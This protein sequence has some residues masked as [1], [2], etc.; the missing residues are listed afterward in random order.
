MRSGVVT[1]LLLANVPTLRACTEDYRTGQ[2]GQE[3][4][5][6]HAAVASKSS[7]CSQIGT[8]IMEQHDGGVVD[9][10]VATLACLGVDTM[11]SCG[12]GGDSIWMYYERKSGKVYSIIARSMAPLASNI[13]MFVNRT[14]DILEGGVYKP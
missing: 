1:L 14:S 3:G 9:A 13:T 6:K 10:A 4:H 2:H 7:I 8:K 11:Q 5:F 12:L